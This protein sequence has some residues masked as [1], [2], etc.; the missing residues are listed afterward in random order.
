M[1]KLPAPVTSDA[2]G[3]TLLDEALDYYHQTIKASPEALKYLEARGLTHSE[4]VDRFKLV[5]RVQQ[6]AQ[7]SS[8]DGRAAG[9]QL[10]RNATS[11]KPQASHQDNASRGLRASGKRPGGRARRRETR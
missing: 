6:P 10:Q 4:L 3:Q 1:R 5:E 11:T 9:C 7:F 2:D 8:T